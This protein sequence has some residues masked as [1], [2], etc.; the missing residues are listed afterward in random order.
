MTK[1]SRNSVD[2]GQLKEWTDCNNLSEKMQKEFSL[3]TDKE[4][5]PVRVMND[6]SGNRRTE[7]DS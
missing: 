6:S 1:H 3:R 5:F 2:P 7:I 4:L